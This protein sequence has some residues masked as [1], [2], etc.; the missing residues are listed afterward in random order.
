MWSA[1]LIVGAVLFKMW[2]SWPQLPYQDYG[3]GGKKCGLLF[4]THLFILIYQTRNKM[5][6][7]GKRCPQTDQGQSIVYG[8]VTYRFIPFVFVSVLNRY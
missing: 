5:P 8:I 1:H 2:K 7:Q 4:R 3:T 6:C